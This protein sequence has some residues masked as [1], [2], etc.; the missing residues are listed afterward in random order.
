[1]ITNAQSKLP[2]RG[3]DRGRGPCATCA[4]VTQAL[5]SFG[6]DTG[7]C[8]LKCYML[9]DATIA[10]AKAVVPSNVVYITRDEARAASG[11]A[12][13]FDLVGNF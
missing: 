10:K 3:F 13:P 1:M 5:W 11:P 4:R 6:T 9:N 12:L 7:F 2:I 8:S